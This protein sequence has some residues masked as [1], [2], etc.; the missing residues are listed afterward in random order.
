MDEWMR[1]QTKSWTMEDLRAFS[2]VFFKRPSTFVEVPDVPFSS[3]SMHGMRQDSHR[4]GYRGGYLRFV[5]ALQVTELD[6]VYSLSH[7]S[8]FRSDPAFR[9]TA[10]RGPSWCCFMPAAYRHE[11]VSPGAEVTRRNAIAA[12]PADI[13]RILAEVAFLYKLPVAQVMLPNIAE[14][15]YFMMLESTYESADASGVGTWPHG[16][17]ITALSSTVIGLLRLGLQVY[18]DGRMRLGLTLMPAEGPFEASILPIA[19]APKT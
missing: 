13:E 16:R 6:Q 19:Y 2:E 3:E 15:M 17:V 12:N 4:R 10:T 7:A 8:V 1:E 5:P 9:E 14:L 18:F 11:T